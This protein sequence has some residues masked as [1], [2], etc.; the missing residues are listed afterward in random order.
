M[1]FSKCSNKREKSWFDCLKG[2]TIM[3]FISKVSGLFVLDHF[4]KFFVLLSFSSDCFFKHFHF[5]HFFAIN[6]HMRGRIWILMNLFA[7]FCRDAFVLWKHF[8]C[9][10][11]QRAERMS[12]GRYF[13]DFGK[14]SPRSLTFRT[15]MNERVQASLLLAISTLKDVIE[16]VGIWLFF[17]WDFPILNHKEIV[18]LRVHITVPLGFG[19]VA[20]WLLLL[21]RILYNSVIKVVRIPHDLRLSFEN[22]RNFIAFH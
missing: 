1:R 19:S 14:V 10:I 4:L 9:E 16:W 3:H 15:G 6:F 21:V 5:K 17:C 13:T 2:T 22:D 8:A 7:R 20:E 12:W 18:E 11:R